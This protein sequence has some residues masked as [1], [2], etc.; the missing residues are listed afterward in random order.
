MNEIKRFY[1]RKKVI[2]GVEYTA[3]FN[4]LSAA[5]KIVDNN[6]VSDKSSNISVA[7]MSQYVL[8]NFIVTPKGLKV[9]DFEDMD[10][11]NEVVKFATEVAQGKFRDTQDET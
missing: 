2:G 7:S 11:L 6:Y 3:Q 8:D 5:M 9:D 1:Q 4:G 10:V